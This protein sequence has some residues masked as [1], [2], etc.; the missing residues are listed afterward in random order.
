[1]PFTASART[2]PDEGRMR[3]LA[4]A[5][6]HLEPPFAVLDE[7]ALERNAADLVARAAGRPIRLASKSVRVRSLLAE[8]LER[9][10]FAGIL[11]FSLP[12]ALWLAGEGFDDLLVA[13]PTVDR[14]A[15]AAL[16][17]DPVARE[18]V[19]IMVDD[20]AQLDVV[21]A[22]IGRSAPPRCVRVALDVDASL[23]VG[24]LHLGARRSPVHTPEQ[25]ASLA[26]SV[27]RRPWARLVGVMLYDAQVA[28]Q[29]DS[30]VLRRVKK[31]SLEDLDVRRSQ[32]VAA[33]RELADEPLLVN[34]GGTGSLHL[35]SRD[36][37]VTEVAAG[38]GLFAP[39]LFDGYDDFDPQPA[40]YFVTSVVRVPAPG[41]VTCFG[42]G[43]P[44]SGPHGRSRQPR[45]VW[46]RGL[47]LL[48]REGAGEVQTPLAGRGAM[49]L[50][51]G[52][53]VWFRHAKAGELCERFAIL[54]GVDAAG[55][56]RE[57]PTYRGE[58]RCFG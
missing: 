54:Y 36:D 20:A 58:G 50:R 12:E 45:P 51:P 32:V 34:A 13:Y 21:E 42:G 18:R 30:P 27:A 28:G 16:A 24:P 39:T 11:A 29:Q 49:G 5:T 44:A 57:L 43:Y 22:A 46:P 8:T 53:R 14:A 19:T 10:G 6:A 9:P 3:A 4:R 52:D 40:A 47:H 35:V 17:A 2:T 15:L 55:T 48:G 41:L 1:M 7:V 31:A 26:R 25:A 23:K 33:V 37:C 56:V 38:S